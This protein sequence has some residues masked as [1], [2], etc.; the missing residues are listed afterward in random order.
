MWKCEAWRDRK[1]LSLV[2]WKGLEHLTHRFVRATHGAL[3]LVADVSHLCR[4]GC[5][6]EDSPFFSVLKFFRP[7]ATLSVRVHILAKV[8]DYIERTQQLACN[9]MV[10][11]S[12]RLVGPN[13]T[14]F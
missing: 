8:V 3:I 9:P 10:T 11:A 4:N 1:A 13:L 5:G 12:H 6:V 7:S 2:M 14:F